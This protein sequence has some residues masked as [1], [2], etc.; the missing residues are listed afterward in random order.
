[1]PEEL[2]SFCSPKVEPVKLPG[3]TNPCDDA[4]EIVPLKEFDIIVLPVISFRF[5]AVIAKEAAE[6]K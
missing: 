5:W 3:P 1:M 2:K 4:E 6:V